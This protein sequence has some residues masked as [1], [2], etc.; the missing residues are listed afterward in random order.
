MLLVIFDLE[1]TRPIHNSERMPRSCRDLRETGNNL[2]GLYLISAYDGVKTVYCEF[3]NRREHYDAK[4]EDRGIRIF[5]RLY[6]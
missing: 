5:S 4:D 1:R 2:N 6:M 3:K